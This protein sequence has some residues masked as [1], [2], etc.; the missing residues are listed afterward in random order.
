[1]DANWGNPGNPC[2]KDGSGDR[3]FVSTVHQ[4]AKKPE[5][6][7]QHPAKQSEPVA[8]HPATMP[9]VEFGSQICIDAQD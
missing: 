4:S 1:M 9:K 6:V 3:L 5:R 7:T 2:P 8:Q